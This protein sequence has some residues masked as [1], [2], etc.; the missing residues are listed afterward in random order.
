M[1]ARSAGKPMPMVQGDRAQVAQC[2]EPEARRRRRAWQPEPYPTP[3]RAAVCNG[4]QPSTGREW[5][6]RPVLPRSSVAVAH[7]QGPAGSSCSGWLGRSRGAR[8]Q[9]TR[10]A[11]LW[12][13]DPHAAYGRPGCGTAGVAPLLRW[14]S[15]VAA[16]PGTGG[17]P[18]ATNA[19]GSLVFGPTHLLSRP[20]QVEAVPSLSLALCLKFSPGFGD[21]LMWWRDVLAVLGSRPA[22]SIGGRGVCGH[23]VRPVGCRPVAGIGAVGAATGGGSDLGPEGVAP[24]LAATSGLVRRHK[25]GHGASVPRAAIMGHVVVG[26]RPLTPV[27]AQ[28]ARH[29]RVPT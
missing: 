9:R 21:R 17:A 26:V 23:V 24:G 3:V 29:H 2:A 10:G 5:F 27:Q 8:T 14:H 28:E 7:V 19:Q 16:G 22:A 4:G 13:R 20:G 6:G 12:G 11:W 15:R 1:D 18:T 25:D